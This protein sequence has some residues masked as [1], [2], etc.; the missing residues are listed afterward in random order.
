MIAAS[1]EP[2]NLA[3]IEFSRQNTKDGRFNFVLSNGV[4]TEGEKGVKYIS[5][6]IPQDKM[7]KKV[8][9]YSNTR[10]R[11]FEFFDENNKVILTIGKCREG[12]RVTKE[13]YRVTEVLLEDGEKII[14]VVYKLYENWGVRFLDPLETAITDF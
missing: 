9:I 8:K 3:G 10:V 2:L 1:G 5:G 6:M 11:G 12:Y 7:T 4:K 14:G 13:G